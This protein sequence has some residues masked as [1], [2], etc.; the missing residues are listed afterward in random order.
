MF[1]SNPVC[2]VL[3]LV[4]IPILTFG[5]LRRSSLV[6][7]K[8]SLH[9]NLRSAPLLARIPAAA[10]V[11]TWTFMVLALARPVLVEA[12]NTATIESRDIVI[13]LDVSSSMSAAVPFP[14]AS[15][16]LCQMPQELDAAQTEGTESPPDGQGPQA[17][18]YSRLDAA[19]DAALMFVACRNGDRVG[20]QPFA[21]RAFTGWP[22]TADLQIVYTMISL[23]GEYTGTSTNFDGPT[24]TSG[25][26]GALQAAINHFIEI[27][28]AETRV[29]VMVTDG[30][31][32][33]V[34]AR[35]DELLEQ[36]REMNVRIYVLGVGNGWAENKTQDLRR[37]VEAL[38]GVV[39]PV[40]DADQMRAA[41]DRIDQLEKSE[42]VIETAVTYREIYDWFL[43][44]CAIAFLAWLL[45]S[46]LVYED[47]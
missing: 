35:F 34:R 14:T 28:H 17:R 33:I 19:R 42:V 5:S 8:V 47:M 44:A 18:S 11:F 39:I 15:E 26:I 27:G 10:L 25:K 36:M 23:A 29:L 16:Q 1:F 41:F 12:H 38:G 24:G 22:L 40:E 7:T 9:K 13:S 37:F 31:D 2:L 46:A 3:L 32:T 45:S 43:I 20:Y 21:E 30:E 4:V 6:H